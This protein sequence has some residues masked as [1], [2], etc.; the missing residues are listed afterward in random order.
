MHRRLLPSPTLSSQGSFDE[1]NRGLSLSFQE[2][3]ITNRLRLIVPAGSIQF[4]LATCFIMGDKRSS[5]NWATVHSLPPGLPKIPCTIN[6][7][8][9]PFIFRS[10]FYQSSSGTTKSVQQDYRNSHYVALK[11]KTAETSM[12]NSELSILG[13][14]NQQRNSDP[15]SRHVIIL[16]DCPKHQ[17]PNG[18]HVCI[19]FEA[20]SASVSSLLEQSLEYIN[21]IVLYRYF[22]GDGK[23]NTQTSPYWYLLPALTWRHRWRYSRVQRFICSI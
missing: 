13:Y 19:E 15:M 11:I 4:V 20:S 9:S 10:P 18:K 7:V 2:F 1:F 3:S 22:P 14:L 17:G 21:G 6:P 12:D 23:R 5:G 8:H 16:L